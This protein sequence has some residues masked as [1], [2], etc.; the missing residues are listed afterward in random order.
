MADNSRDFSGTAQYITKTDP[1]GILTDAA[2]TMG[3]W[4]NPDSVAG[5][6]I[7]HAGSAGAT[8]RGAYLRITGAN[9]LE[10]RVSGDFATG[11]T[12]IGTG[13][14]IRVGARKAA[15][16][17]SQVYLI[18]NG[19][20][21][22]NSNTVAP[23]EI[24][25]GDVFQ[26][27]DA[28]GGLGDGHFN[29]KMAWLFWLQGVALSAANLDAALQD[30]QSLVTNYGP[31]GVITANALKILWPM[32][33]DNATEVDKSGVGNDGTYTGPPTL[34]SADGP[35]PSTAWDPCAAAA[36]TSDA[37]VRNGSGFTTF[38]LKRIVRRY[39]G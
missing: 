31:S 36:A 7:V 12:S 33:C 13:S 17:T 16:G 5:K 39:A 14:W 2:W 37:G 27:S 1:T 35:S 8:T 18:L 19:A 38:A 21:D 22:G 30:P 34:G 4:I 11:G 32:Q 3:V 9:K 10:C 23:T 6:G 20:D 28:I 26:A 15:A 29:G 25:A 24:T